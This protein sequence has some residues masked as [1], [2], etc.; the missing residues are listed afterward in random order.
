MARRTKIKKPL[1]LLLVECLS[2]S[3]I[4]RATLLGLRLALQRK[5]VTVV[6]FS[7]QAEKLIDPYH[8]C[9]GHQQPLN[10]STNDGI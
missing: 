9:P 6:H 1:S 4:K 2:L 5:A 7:L 8:L 10:G 3:L